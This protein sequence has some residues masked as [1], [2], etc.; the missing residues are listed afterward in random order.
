MP[1][2]RSIAT[3]RPATVVTPVVMIDGNE[4]ART[5]QVDSITIRKEV[6]RVPWAKVVILDGNASTGSFSASN[7]ALFVPGKEIEVK[8]GYQNDIYSIF[9][10]II[11]CHA[12][13]LRGNANSM[14]VLECRDKTVKMT[15]GRKSR[16][17]SDQKDSDIISLIAGDYVSD[18]STTAEATLVTHKEMVQYDCSDWDFILS[19]ADA[20]GKICICD[21]GEFSV[22]APDPEQS[23]VLSLL[24]GATMME[25]DAEIDARHQL[26]KVTSRSWSYS[27][28][29]IV[30]AEGSDPEVSLNGN[31][32][33]AELA[34][35]IGL[36]D[37]LLDHG[38]KVE[39]KE[40]QAWSDALLLKR[41]LARVRGRVK[42]KG[43]HT[44]TPGSIIELGGIGE[45][46]NGNAFVSGVQHFISAGDWTLDIQFG[47]E[48]EWFTRKSDIGDKPAGGL[49][50]A[51]HGLQV[52]VVTKIDSD[53]DSENRI[54]VR[55]PIISDSEEGIWARIATLDA[56]NERGSFFLP[57][58]GDEVIV[59]FI[60]DDPRDAIV[61]GMLNSSALPAA[62]TAEES[63]PKKGFV[64]RSKMKM[65]FDDEKK[66]FSIETPAGKTI[67]LDEDADLIKITD[68]HQNS[69]VMDSSGIVIESQGKIEIKAQQDLKLGGMNVEMNAQA[70]MKVE[71]SAS[72][73]LKAGGTMTV[74]G[75]MVQ[76]N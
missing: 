46:F 2:D 48:P 64:T 11:V 42:C 70:S 74:K 65:I 45:R 38:G 63:N 10:G 40:L 22:K 62:L 36:D 43:V 55:L 37:Y 66:Q 24:F 25:F 17:F 67:I 29:R 41:Q 44:V 13:K 75:A 52:G 6:N 9:K 35:V 14:L 30:K 1:E 49:L 28:Q 54:K 32:S 58:V 34:D 59:G 73:E 69:L 31:I 61:L 53:P 72:A 27:D 50:S 60:N 71:G 76:I 7:D 33:S 4:I 19:R 47:M 51:L 68:D 21:G 26:G 18:F 56:G 20:N 12:V 3:T 57:E 16:Y 5:W 39:D 8:C 23:S 15:V